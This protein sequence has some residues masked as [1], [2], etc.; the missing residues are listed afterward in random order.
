MP[1]SREQR[2]YF[3]RASVRCSGVGFVCLVVLGYDTI[4][5]RPPLD[6]SGA[7]VTAVRVSGCRWCS[8]RRPGRLATSAPIPRSIE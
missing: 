7:S 5:G 4:Y 2:G 6:L 3:S 1:D 8:S